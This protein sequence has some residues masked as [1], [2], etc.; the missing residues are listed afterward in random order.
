MLIK[1]INNEEVI[2]HYF[3]CLETGE[4]ENF[5]FS[6]ASEWLSNTI[7]EILDSY[8]QF[9]KDFFLTC[10]I[11]GNFPGW[12]TLYPGHYD[13]Q[14]YGMRKAVEEACKNG[15]LYC[16]FDDPIE[17]CEDIETVRFH[18]LDNVYK[19][20]PEILNLKENYNNLLKI[21]ARDDIELS[22]DEKIEIIKNALKVK[23]PEKIYLHEYFLR[24]VI[25]LQNMPTAEGNIFNLKNE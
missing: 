24:C 21:F 11:D 10:R 18:I 23:Y 2:K 4:W 16:S 13:E 7:L 8:G 25:L 12:T 14:G 22:Q 17:A 9:D 3:Q 19:Y 1:Y 5:D 6:D 15:N 20:N